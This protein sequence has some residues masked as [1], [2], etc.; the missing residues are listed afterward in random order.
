MQQ[1]SLGMLSVISKGVIFRKYVQSVG[2]NNAVLFKFH[3]AQPVHMRGVVGKRHRI[4]TEEEN[5]LEK[6]TGPEDFF[7]IESDD[8]VIHVRNK[9]QSTVGKPSDITNEVSLK[10]EHL[11]RTSFG[12]V[13]FDSDNRPKIHGQFETNVAESEFSYGTDVE[14]S[15]IQDL[16]DRKGKEASIIQKFSAGKNEL[17]DSSQCTKERVHTVTE[18]LVMKNC[19]NR[20]EN[21]DLGFIDRTYFCDGSNAVRSNSDLHKEE[22]L[23]FDLTMLESSVHGKEEKKGNMEVPPNNCTDQFESGSSYIDSTYFEGLYDASSPHSSH[24]PE[25]RSLPSVHNETDNAGSSSEVKTEENVSRE[26]NFIDSVYFGD[27]AEGNFASQDNG[28]PGVCSISETHDHNDVQANSESK[29]ISNNTQIESSDSLELIQGVQ[30]NLTL[31]SEQSHGMSVYKSTAG[32]SSG[33]LEETEMI[34]E[35]AK[36]L[37]VNETELCDLQAPADGEEGHSAYKYVLQLRKAEVK[38]NTQK[39]EKFD[40]KGFR[41]LKDQVP[42]LSQLTRNELTSLLK[43]RVLFSN[44]DIVILNKPYNLVVH[45]SQTTNLP[46]LSSVLDNLAHELDNVSANPQLYTVHRLDKETTGCLLLARSEIAAQKLKALFVQRQIEKNYLVVT[47]RVPYPCEGIIDIPIAEGKI[48]NRVRMVLQPDIPKEMKYKTHVKDGKRA[49]TYYKVVATSEN[50]A[51]LEVRP[52]TGLKHQIRVHLG[53][54]L[55]CPVLG[56]HKYSHLTKLAPQRLSTDILRKLE[57]RQSKVRY[58]PMH[59]HSRNVVIPEYLEGRDLYVSAPLPEHM[60]NTLKW[61]KFKNL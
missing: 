35:L 3:T 27:V 47:T 43:E 45:E 28:N 20:N 14:K 58:V 25:S 11:L 24:H 23:C 6:V 12:H 57:I 42:D 36:E 41:I 16:K 18:N 15:R 21:L 46:A 52:E 37:R 33:S 30:E 60:K 54:G 61:L 32:L 56:D 44:D 40:S 22:E 29:N 4:S 7:G 50:A 9:V 39:G 59:I 26:L 1:F 8:G 55:N 2:T 17:S 13:R 49:I 19:S 38:Q 53:F 10:K 48:E 31:P 34:K 5:G 51:L